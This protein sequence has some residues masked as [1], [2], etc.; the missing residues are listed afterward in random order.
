MNPYEIRPVGSGWFEEYLDDLLAAGA[1]WMN[2]VWEDV[3]QDPVTLRA[4][5]PAFNPHVDPVLEGYRDLYF[6]VLAQAVY[7]YLQE[8]EQRLLLE[9]RMCFAA[10]RVHGDRCL[11][12]EREYFRPDPDRSRLLDVILSRVIHPEDPI[13]CQLEH[14]RLA[15]SR[16]RPLKISG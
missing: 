16:V 14:I 13:R 5:V 3:P 2:T 6:A 4:A 12:M 10:A 8:Y 7:D 9:D 1:E 11:Q 15:M